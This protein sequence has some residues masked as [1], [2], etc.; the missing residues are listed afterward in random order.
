MGAWDATAVEQD[1]GITYMRFDPTMPS[2]SPAIYLSSQV[3]RASILVS[4]QAPGGV[5]RIE[6]AAQGSLDDAS[7]VYGS[8]LLD[9]RWRKISETRGEAPARD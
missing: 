9:L 2:Q 4:K 6:L 7:S 3:V 8:S 5:A 1:G